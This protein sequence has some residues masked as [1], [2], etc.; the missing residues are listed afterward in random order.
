MCCLFGLIDTRHTLSGKDKS[1]I[2]HILASESEARGTDA[3]GI[4]YH[5]GNHLYIHKRPIPGHK[6]QIWVSDCLL[7]TSPSPRD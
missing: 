4:A 6:L 2:V 7:Y 1:K 3:T 5:F